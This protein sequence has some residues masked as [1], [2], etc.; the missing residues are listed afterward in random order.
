MAT[1]VRTCVACLTCLVC[2]ACVRTYVGVGCEPDAPRVHGG[3]GWMGGMVVDVGTW[4]WNSGLA[5]TGRR[6]D[7]VRTYVLAG[8]LAPRVLA[9]SPACCGCWLRVLAASLACLACL[10]TSAYVRK[11]VWGSLSLAE[12]RQ[13]GWL[14]VGS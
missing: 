10:R 5:G 13:L 11:Y 3:R 4:L 7:V 14:G 9:A 1:Y 2:L 12:S 8:S 6:M